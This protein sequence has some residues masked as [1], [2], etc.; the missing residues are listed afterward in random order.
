MHAMKQ[1]FVCHLHR[2][3]SL[4]LHCMEAMKTKSL[5][6]I[7]LDAA[8]AI[9]SV[10][11]STLW[12]RVTDGL[13]GKAGNDDR[14]RAMLLLSDVLE[15]VDTPTSMN[16]EDI[17]MLLAAD[18][19]VPEA[20]ADIGA[21]FYVAGNTKAALYWL[22]QAADNNNADAMHW[23]AIAH[24]AHTPGTMQTE[25]PFSTEESSFINS[26]EREENLAVMWLAKAAALGH[27]LA[28][29]QMSHIRRR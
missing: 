13:I 23:L 4:K 26:S 18:A 19:G 15:L 27:P 14:N 6:R 8:V 24:A 28:R 11:K 22:Y 5:D 1:R 21:M 17:S 29:Q 9:S 2:Q 12:R 3:K 7:S 20:Q 25:Q 16:R 10:S